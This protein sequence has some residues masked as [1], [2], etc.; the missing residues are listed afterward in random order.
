MKVILN[1]HVEHLG[2]RGQKVE[3]KPGYARN[4]LLPKGLAYADTPGNWRRFEQEQKHWEDMDLSRRT[5]AEAV[6]ESL[7]GT[8]LV[9]ERRAGEKDVLFG[10]VNISDI[11]RRLAALGYEIDKKRVLLRETIK[12]LG[13]FETE[14]QIHRDIRVTIPIHVVRPGEQPVTADEEPP[15][16]ESGAEPAEDVV[17]EPAE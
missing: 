13:S 7:T 4:Y 3:V 10:S 16:E 2:E 14:V 6:A 15:A 9:F 1:D 12:A 11:A 8:E 17:Q 5:A